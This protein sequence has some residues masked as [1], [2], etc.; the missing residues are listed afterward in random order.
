MIVQ[1]CY[2]S[3]K[4]QKKNTNAARWGRGCHHGGKERSARP[5]ADPES[6]DMVGNDLT[7]SYD[8]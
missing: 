5:E 8:T 3:T 4:T 2:W 1:L 7:T 6:V